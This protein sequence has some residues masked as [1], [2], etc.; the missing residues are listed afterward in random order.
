DLIYLDFCGPLPS[1]KAGQKTLKA[2]TSILKYHALSPLGVMITNVSL[3][4]KEQNAN[5]HKNI[6]NLVA[7]YLYPKSTLESN[8]PEWNCT[9]GAI[10][11]GYSLDEWHKKVE[12]EI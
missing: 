5:E 10:S 6:V 11:E 8:N 9:D 2:I 12:C 1:K 7:S 3:P 4:S